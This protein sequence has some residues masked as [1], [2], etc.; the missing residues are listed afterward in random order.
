M[1]FTMISDRKQCI[2][3][4]H[5]WGAIIGWQFVSKYK[6]MVEKYVMMGAP[7]R[8]VFAQL[9]SETTDQFKRYGTSYS[10]KCQWFLKWFT[11]PMI[12]R[13]F[14]NYGRSFFHK[15]ISKHINMF[16]QSQVNNKLVIDLNQFPSIYLFETILMKF[17]LV[18]WIH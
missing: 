13:C 9:F 5:D 16:S 7:S 12:L 15:K 14:Y 3:V 8:A 4:C 2:L 17:F 18:F 10:F 6:Y 1:T 11:V